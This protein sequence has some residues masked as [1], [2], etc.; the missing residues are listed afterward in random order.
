MA[1]KLPMNGDNSTTAFIRRIFHT[2]KQIFVSN[3]VRSAFVQIRVGYNIDVVP[4]R[5]IF[6]QSKLRQ[7]QG[8]LTLWHRNYP[9][10]QLSTRGRSARFEWI[11]R[12][13]HNNLME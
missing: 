11:N 12:E 8:F 10:E 1:Y 6:D 2:T 3:N 13:V 4:D 5:L 7:S 9:L